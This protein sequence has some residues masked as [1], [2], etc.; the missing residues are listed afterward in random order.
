[1]YVWE[2][3][4]VALKTQRPARL[5]KTFL[6]QPLCP[7]NTPT[8]MFGAVKKSKCSLIVF[9]FLICK[10]PFLPGYTKHYLSLKFYDLTRIYLK[11]SCSILTSFLHKA[12]AGLMFFLKK[13]YFYLFIQKV[14]WQRDSERQRTHPSA[15]SLPKY[16]QQPRLGQVETRGQDFIL[17][18]YG[19][20]SAMA[21][22]CC[23]P[24]ASA[25]SQT[26]SVATKSWVITLI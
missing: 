15:V 5:G 18:S 20:P 16:P 6:S 23:F 3:F 21:I 2:Q 26:G 24:G 19:D 14:K 12:T 7:Q 1:M 11:I 17:I 9:F 10:L 13:V 22:I 25:E 8:G 4:T